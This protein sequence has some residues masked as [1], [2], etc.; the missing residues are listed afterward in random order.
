MKRKNVIVDTSFEFA[1][2][3]IEYAEILEEKRKIIS[4][5]KS[6]LK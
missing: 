3:I 1:L 5:T 6:G 4:T 2:L